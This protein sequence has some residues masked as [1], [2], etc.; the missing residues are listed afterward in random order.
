MAVRFLSACDSVTHAEAMVRDFENNYVH[1]GS[2]NCGGWTQN[3]SS[4][5]VSGWRT[6]IAQH[7]SDFGCQTQVQ[8]DRL[9][10]VTS[11]AH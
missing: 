8:S 10:R 1:G 6:R 9:T 3:T 4:T 7:R 5:E 2:Y 11:E